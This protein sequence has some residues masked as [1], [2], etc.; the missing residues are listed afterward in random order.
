MRRRPGTAGFC[1][2]HLLLPEQ[3][4]QVSSVVGSAAAERN[5]LAA[6]RPIHRLARLLCPRQSSLLAR[7]I[8]GPRIEGLRPKD[9]TV[10]GD[11]PIICGRQAATTPSQGNSCETGRRG[12]CMSRSAIS[13][14]G[15]SDWCSWPSTGMP[16]EVTR[17][18]HTFHASFRTEGQVPRGMVE[19]SSPRL[20]LFR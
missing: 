6:F 3:I 5:R 18:P 7:R 1:Q 15:P 16:L 2:L 8:C 12:P 4:H 19:A 17:H 20:T 11:R 13:E 9:D 10:H 14:R